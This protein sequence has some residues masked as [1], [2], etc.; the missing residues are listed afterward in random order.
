MGVGVPAPTTAGVGVDVG[1]AEFDTR[2]ARG[3]EAG[4]PLTDRTTWYVPN[5]MPEGTVKSTSLSLH[6]SGDGF[7]DVPG[8]AACA[9]DR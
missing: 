2:K 5:W 8:V 1:L 9:H 4:A 6:D 3:F 7:D